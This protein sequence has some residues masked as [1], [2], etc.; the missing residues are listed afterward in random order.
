[1][2]KEKEQGG[3]KGGA[4]GDEKEKDLRHRVRAGRGVEVERRGD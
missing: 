4:V 1:M 3:G 2:V